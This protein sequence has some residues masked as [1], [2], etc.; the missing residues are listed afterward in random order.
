[1]ATWAQLQNLKKCRNVFRH[2]WVD[3]GKR[4]NGSPTYDYECKVCGRRKIK[5]DTYHSIYYEVDGTPLGGL[6]P[7]CKAVV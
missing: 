6:A 4:D 5:C 1:M 7:D 3:K 2:K